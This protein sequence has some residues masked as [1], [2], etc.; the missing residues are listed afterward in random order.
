[1][2]MDIIQAIDTNAAH[3]KNLKQEKNPLDP[4][5]LLKQMEEIPAEMEEILIRQGVEPF[6]YQQPEFDPKRQ[7]IVKT[8]ITHD[9]LK[10]KTIAQQVHNGYE[11]ERKVLCRER[12]NV[13]L[14]EP[15]PEELKTNKKE[16]EEQ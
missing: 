12:V 8:V 13:Y 3:V 4:Q 9:R 5:E 2:I 1:M 16:E 14:Y 15:D 10:D 11:R 6:N 7:K